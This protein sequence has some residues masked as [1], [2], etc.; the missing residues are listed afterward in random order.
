MGLT[1]VVWASLLCAVVCPNFR[2]L[3]LSQ[4]LSFSV[5]PHTLTPPP[6]GTY[7]VSIHSD[8]SPFPPFH[9]TVY[10]RSPLLFHSTLSQAWASLYFLFFGVL[11]HFFFSS[12]FSGHCT[13]LF[14]FFQNVE[15]RP[16]PPPITT[17]HLTTHLHITFQ[18]LLTHTSLYLELRVR[19][20][21]RVSLRSLRR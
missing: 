1:S 15:K 5:F 3:S 12:S 21:H 9:P 17:T 6:S 18:P 10:S 14:F 19:L 7:N 8:F 16:L 13:G 11:S 2:P 4:R 20:S